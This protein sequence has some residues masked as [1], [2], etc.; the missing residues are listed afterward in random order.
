[1]APKGA[2][3]SKA[4]SSSGYSVQNP[5]DIEKKIAD[6]MAKQKAEQME[7]R[8]K[9]SMEDSEEEEEEAPEDDDEELREGTFDEAAVPQQD[10]T[11]ERLTAELADLKVA[12][13]H[14]EAEA[15]KAR[16]L[17]GAKETELE[18]HLKSKGSYKFTF[19][20]GEP[21]NRLIFYEKQVTDTVA[22]LQIDAAK[23]FGV[24]QRKKAWVKLFDNDG[25]KITGGK[26][27]GK[28]LTSF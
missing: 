27:G 18:T 9:K 28:K 22:S 15:K 21:I 5:G 19:E 20:Y 24:P 8:N 23:V 7:E 6:E 26:Q 11:V 16:Q 3:K 13:S 17:R 10:Q 25:I 14:H 4:A 12:S 1:M 2:P